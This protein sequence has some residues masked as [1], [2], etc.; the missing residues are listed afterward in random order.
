MSDG[1]CGVHKRKGRLSN[2]K[3]SLSLLLPS[4]AIAAA[5]HEI[6]EATGE[7]SKKGNNINNSNSNNN[8]NNNNDN[9]DNNDN[10]K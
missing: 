7:G 9:N 3:E 5:N 6:V 2:L 8:N 1:G 10:N 4:S